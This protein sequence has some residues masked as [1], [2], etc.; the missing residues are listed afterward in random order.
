MQRY[1]EM[2]LQR[3]RNPMHR[4]ASLYRLSTS[5]NLSPTPN[6]RIGNTRRQSLHPIVQ[7]R[8]KLQPETVQP[9]YRRM[10][11]RRFQRVRNFQNSI[12]ERHRLQAIARRESVLGI[13]MR[14]NVR[15]WISDGSQR[16]SDMRMRRPV[17][18]NELQGGGRDVPFGGGR[19][20]R[21]SLSVGPD[22]LAQERKPVS[23]RGTAEVVR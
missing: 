3:L 9:G 16:V 7:P 20:C 21:S 14:G 12:I 5:K 23:E 15:A 10:L 1:N 17:Q 11:V 13:R 18:K 22:V 8:R 2:L 6:P 19:M 4:T